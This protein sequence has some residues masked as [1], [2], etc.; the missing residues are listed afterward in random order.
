MMVAGIFDEFFGVPT[1]PFAVHA[2]IVLIPIV[3]IVSIVVLFRSTWRERASVPIAGLAVVMVGMLF[4]AKESGEALEESGDVLGDVDRH[5]EL[6][7]Q[8]F[9]LGIVWMVVAVVA[10]IAF[11]VVRRRTSSTLSAA[12]AGTDVS[13]IVPALN[14][15]AAIAA[16]VTTIWLVRTGHAGAESRWVG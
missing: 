4:F 6:A 13:W 10:A 5:T 9:T 2:P 15:L 14:A 16:I 8:T 11:L 3:S 12:A 1:H 7:E